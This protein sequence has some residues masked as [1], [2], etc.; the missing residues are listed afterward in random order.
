MWTSAHTDFDVTGTSTKPVPVLQLKILY[1]KYGTRNNN[2]KRLMQA[3]R[4]RVHMLSPLMLLP[5]YYDIPVS[6]K[7]LQRARTEKAPGEGHAGNDRGGTR[8]DKMDSRP[9]QR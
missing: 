5:L 8:M 9:A 7:R 4:N 3:T 6:A 1:S 2:V